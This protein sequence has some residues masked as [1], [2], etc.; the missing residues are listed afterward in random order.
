[1]GQTSETSGGVR[2]MRGRDDEVLWRLVGVCVCGQ[3]ICLIS[4]ITFDHGVVIRHGFA[5]VTQS[6]SDTPDAILPI[7]WLLYSCNI[8]RY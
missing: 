1:M 8:H 6:T 7:S 3:F 2:M 5:R 4:L